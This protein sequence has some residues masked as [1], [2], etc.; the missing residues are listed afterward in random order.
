MSIDVAKARAHH[1]ELQELVGTEL[2]TVAT[3]LLRLMEFEREKM[4]ERLG[5]PSMWEFCRRGLGLC[6][7]TTGRRLKAIRIVERFPV[8]VEYLR[9]GR[10]CTT[11]MLMLG[12]ALTPENVVELIELAA[13]KSIKEIEILVATA[14][15][16][17]T[18]ALR[19]QKLPESRQAVA[20]VPAALAFSSGPAPSDP[21]EATAPVLLSPA[22]EA[23][24]CPP[25]PVRRAEIHPTSA[26]EYLARLPVSRGWVQKLEMAKKLG[27]HVVPAGDP[28]EILELALDL[29]IEKHG[30]RRGAIAVR[31]SRV[32]NKSE[33][34]TPPVVKAPATQIAPSKIATPPA[35]GNA[36]KRERFSAEDRRQI[37]TRDGGRC[38]WVMDSGERCGSEHQLEIDHIEAVGKGGSSDVRLARI[39]CRR[40][41]DQYARETYGEEFMKS[42]RSARPAGV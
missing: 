21:S 14:K 20:A 34:A 38:T 17:P 31:R 3:F 6:E 23:T 4:H 30:K 24:P 13:R 36:T 15:P 42:K 28:V 18:P 7:S 35:D 26:Q 27:S 32:E 2:E 39:L 1:Q 37:W 29:F 25:R 22:S 11:R 9:N 10:L 40:H 33:S 8:V 16:Q 41:N 19:I 12:D 5:Y